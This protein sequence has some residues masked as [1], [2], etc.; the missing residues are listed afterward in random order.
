MRSMAMS[1]SPT[2]GT[3]PTVRSGQLVPAV[4]PVHRLLG[5]PARPF[6]IDDLVVHAQ[7]QGLECEPGPDADLDDP[8]SPAQCEVKPGHEPVNG[9]S[10]YGVAIDHDFL[11]ADPPAVVFQ[12]VRAVGQVDFD[13]AVQPTSAD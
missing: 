4:I 10:A 8:P 7:D 1:T 5:H 2:T 6:G 3:R 9:S 11:A 13:A 12:H